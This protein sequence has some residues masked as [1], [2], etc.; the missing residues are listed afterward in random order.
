MAGFRPA[1]AL[2]AGVAVAV[3]G[4]GAA[5]AAPP[6]GSTGPAPAGQPR[7]VATE[8][9]SARMQDL[10]IDSPALGTQVRVRLLLPASYRAHPERRWPVL[11]LLHG[12]CDTYVSWTRSTDVEALTAR[13][14]LLVVM[15]DGGRAGFYSDWRAGPGWETFHLS[16]LPRLLAGTYHAGTVR[17]VA[18]VSMGGLGALGYTARH[19]GM[20]AAAASFSGIVHTRL[21]PGESAGYQGLV[22]SQGGDPDRLWGDPVRDA[23]V[24]RAHNPYDLA[25][26][27]AGVPLFLSVGTGAPGPYERPGAPADQ[28]EPSLA[29]ENTAL[30]GR[31]RQ[32]GIPVRTDFYGPGIHNWPYWQRELHRAWP[33][34]ERALGLG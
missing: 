8:S 5:P 30:A 31:L 12:C 23:D 17:A 11:Y 21:S 22:R 27:L 32:L 2:F 34:L 19:P 33:M 7:I 24:W 26:K 14:D 4:C 13:S 16:E 6:P 25:P 15:P 3:A 1:A 9:L 29:A 10:T 20:F 18:G 28:I